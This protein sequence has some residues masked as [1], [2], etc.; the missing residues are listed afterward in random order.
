MSKKDNLDKDSRK[1]LEKLEGCWDESPTAWVQ[2]KITPGDL[3]LLLEY[4]APL[5]DLIR[6]IVTTAAGDDPAALVRESTDLRLQASVASS[7]QQAALQQAAC[8]Q[9]ELTSLRLYSQT[10]QKDLQQAVNKVQQLMQENHRLQEV[11]QSGKNELERTRQQLLRSGKP[12]EQL[13]LLRQ[14]G[15]LARQLGLADLPQDDMAALIRVVAVLAQR[16]NMQRLWEV[17]R[18]RCEAEQRA[19]SPAELQLL[20]T[21][22]EWHNHNWQSRPYQLLEVP[23]GA[24]YDFN[25]AQRSQQALAGETV[26]QLRLPGIADGSGKALCKALVLTR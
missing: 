12:P 9:D 23:P 2:E 1:R 20:Q 15:E 3:R 17:L 6:A 26:S 7:A 19:V 4:S 18:S 24:A 11:F 13:A 22:L 8:L 16:D 21:A 25:R 14:D 10:L 5:Q